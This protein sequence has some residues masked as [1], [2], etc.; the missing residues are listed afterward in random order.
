[1]TN[2]LEVL[3]TKVCTK[4]VPSRLYRTLQAPVTVPAETCRLHSAHFH[5]RPAWWWRRYLQCT[6]D[7]TCTLSTSRRC[8]TTDKQKKDHLSRLLAVVKKRCIIGGGADRRLLPATGWWRSLLANCPNRNFV[9]RPWKV[10]QEPARALAQGYSTE[11]IA[12]CD[13][14]AQ[15]RAH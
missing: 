8:R 1:M 3:Q 4:I 9:L 7:V 12:R 13:K 6:L 2:I 5:C 15:S 10:L 14:R 11:T